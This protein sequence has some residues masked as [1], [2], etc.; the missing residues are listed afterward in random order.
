[1]VSHGFLEFKGLI[2]SHGFIVLQ[3]LIVSNGFI[4]AYGLIVSHEFVLFTLFMISKYT[5]AVLL[6]KKKYL[7]LINLLT[8]HKRCNK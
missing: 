5:I 4:M 8:S 1:M 6:H 7:N 3:G 2:V